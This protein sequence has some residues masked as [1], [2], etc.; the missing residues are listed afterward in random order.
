MRQMDPGSEFLAYTLLNTSDA[1]STIIRYSNYFV[2][3][4]ILEISTCSSLLIKG[5]V[6][7]ISSDP[8]SM[9]FISM[10]IILKTDYFL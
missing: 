2:S 3:I 7:V 4:F 10:F 5:T 1:Y 6:G 8:T 9:D